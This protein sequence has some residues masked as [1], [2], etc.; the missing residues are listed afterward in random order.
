[1]TSGNA[2][3]SV[4]MPAYNGQRFVGRTLAS[5]LAQTYNPVEIIVVDDGSTDQTPTIVEAAAARDSRIRLFRRQNSGVAASRNFGISQARGKLI[6]TLDAD[7][8]W[9][10]QKIARQ[11]EVIQASSPNVGLVYCWSIEIDEN[12]LIIPPISTLKTRKRSTAQ[13][14]VTAQLARGCFIE[15]A[16]SPLMKRSDIEAVGGYDPDLQ[17][18]GADDWKLYLALSEICEFAVIPEYLVGYR[19]ASGS[20]SRD[21]TAMG[22]SMVNVARWIFEKRPDL[23]GELR[24]Q[25]MYGLHAFMAQRALDNDQFA[26]GLRFRAKAYRSHPAGLFDPTTFEFVVRFFAR[27]LGL[28]RSELRRRG[29]RPKVSFE[30][31]QAMRP[32]KAPP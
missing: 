7:D 22:Q 11:V 3:V 6:A 12:D 32:L 14:A 27:L 4:V 5:A 13:G 16:S 21:V 19:Q 2:L 8:L 29:L 31:F 18:Q 26:A 17:P 23:P 1:M 24:R 15:T 28:K 10:P 9:H 30:E 25:S 20:L